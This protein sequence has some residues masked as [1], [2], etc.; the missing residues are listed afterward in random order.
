MVSFMIKYKRVFLILT[1]VFFLAS[2]GFI[3]AGVFI[4]EYGPNAAIASV[5]GVK[6]KYKDY[7]TALQLVETEARKSEDYNEEASKQIQQEVLQQM[8]NEASLTQSALG[9]GLGVSDIEV[10]Y[11]I[12]NT[13]A[14]TNGGSFN[15]RDY[16]WTVQ[17]RFN[18]TPYEYESALKKQ[19]LADKF[20]NLLILSAKI[21][22]Q[23]EEML[24]ARRSSVTDKAIK[25]S[26]A[27]EK[28]AK[29]A[30]ALAAVKLKAQSLMNDFIK[31]FNETKQIQI[32]KRA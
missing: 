22:P 23:E 29:T 1:V 7:N 17:N 30:F 19:K 3:G 5:G 6:I 20:Q 16:I 4:E 28:T 12:Q 8:I 25:S 31:R 18:M 15:K 11:S 14:F 32:F 10:A 2:L 13:P 24:Y 21:T 26:G 27:D 9:L